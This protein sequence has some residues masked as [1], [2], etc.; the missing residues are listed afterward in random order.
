MNNLTQSSN[1]YFE[2]SV[3][4]SSP[5]QLVVLLYEAAI[6]HLKQAMTSIEHKDLNGKRQSVDRA[7]AIVQHLQ[8]TLD[9][10]R[11]GQI[12]L[13]LDRLYTYVVFRILDGSAKLSTGPLEEA[14]KLLS[15]LLESWREVAR[16]KQGQVPPAKSVVHVRQAPTIRLQLQG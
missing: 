7:M 12:S 13:E 6:R 9:M 5:E 1:R 10:E 4:T 11:G 2:T 14:V 8:S 3:T 16:Q 15:S